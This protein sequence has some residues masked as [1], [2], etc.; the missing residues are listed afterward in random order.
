MMTKWGGSGI[1]ITCPGACGWY[2]WDLNLVPSSSRAWRLSRSPRAGPSS[3]PW[4]WRWWCAEAFL[5][6][7]SLAL[8]NKYMGKVTF[9]WVSDCD[10]MCTH[11]CV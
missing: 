9:F 10:P 8:R 5:H 3:S 6:L 1:G 7:G 2:R 4:Q 11:L